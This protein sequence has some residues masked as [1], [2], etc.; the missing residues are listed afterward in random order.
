MPQSHLSNGDP[1][2][3][4][5]DKLRLYSM[6]FCPYAERPRLVLA[7]KGVD[8]E[9]ININLKNKPDWYLAE[10]NPRGLVPMIEMPDGRLLPESLLCCG[11][12]VPMG[13]YSLGKMYPGMVYPGGS[14]PR[15]GVP[16]A[17]V[18]PMGEYL[19]ELFPQNPMYPSDAFEKNRQRLLID[20]FGKV[21]SSFY[22]ML[23]RDMDEDALK[24]QTET[25]NKELSLYENELKNK[26]FF[27]GEKPG[28]ADFMLW[29]FFER[30]CLLEGKYEISA[31]SFPA[32]TKW[33]SSMHQDPA[34]KD[35]EFSPALLRRNF[36]DSVHKGIPEAALYE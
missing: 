9:C 18:Y 30:F 19:D 4:P 23:M 14:V 13:G 3:P 12:G 15:G 26:T 6:R 36:V 33:I 10:P 11:G 21:T 2:P 24:G 7:A 35:V 5:G 32:L 22:Q 17:E 31:K 29:P 16:R 8:Y 25:L 34:V 20:R 1:R 28:M 27:A